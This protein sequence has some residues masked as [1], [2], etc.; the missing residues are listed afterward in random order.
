[1]AALLGL[2]L[3]PPWALLREEPYLAAAELLA[4]ALGLGTLQ[5]ARAL[6]GRALFLWLAAHSSALLAEWWDA[7]SPDA[8]D[9]WHARGLLTLAR[10]RVPL[11][12]VVLRASLLYISALTAAR[13]RMRAL[14]SALACSLRE[15]A[16]APSAA[17]CG[18]RHALARPQPSR[19]CRSDCAAARAL[20]PRWRQAA[21]V[22]GRP[23]FT[24]ARG[25]AL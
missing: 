4:L 24:R 21:V 2:A 25:A 3:R 20:P 16:L 22:D 10:Y 9:V 5:H 18:P 23:W 17:A 11:G 6:S 8:Q 19:R 15:C 13:L 14:S 7:R 1:M 12:A